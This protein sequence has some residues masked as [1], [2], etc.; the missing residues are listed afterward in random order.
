VHGYGRGYAVGSFVGEGPDRA[1]CPFRPAWVIT[2]PPFEPAQEFAL[3]ALEEAT[4]G[5][6]IFARSNWSE[7]KRR[8]E[9][10]FGPHPPAFE[11]QFVER[12]PLVKGRWDPEASTATSYSW[13]V[14]LR[15]ATP[16]TFKVWIPPGQRRRLERVDD[17][18]RFAPPPAMPLFPEAAG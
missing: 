18:R 1:Q 16:D 9:A 15:D 6:A 8:Y 12:V 2:N 10:I 14:W 5:V 4:Y 13:F 11:C 7:G 3:R 17:R